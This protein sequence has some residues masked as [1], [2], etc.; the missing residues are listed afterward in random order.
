MKIIGDEVH[1]FLIRFLHFSGSYKSAS[2]TAVPV[3]QSNGDGPVHFH[4][5]L[6][7]NLVILKDRT[8]YLTYPLAPPCGFRG[9]V[10]VP[11]DGEFFLLEDLLKHLPGILDVSYDSNVR[12]FGQEASTCKY[13]SV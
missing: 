8:E 11:F 10:V 7:I 13:E 2:P 3:H 5:D 12:N 6:E 1:D 9:I 4:G